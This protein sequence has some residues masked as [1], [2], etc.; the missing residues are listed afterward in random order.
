MCGGGGA[1]GAVCG[2]NGSMCGGR[3]RV[4]GMTGPPAGGGG[5]TCG[6]VVTSLSKMGG[7]N[8]GGS[9]TTRGS[10]RSTIGGSCL[11]SICGIGWMM[12]GC[13]SSAGTSTYSSTYSGT[14]ISRIFST[15]TS[16]T[17]AS[18]PGAPGTPRGPDNS[19]PAGGGT[20][21]GK[22]MIFSTMISCSSI[23]STGTWMMRPP[24]R[25]FS[26]GWGPTGW[27]TSTM[28]PGTITGTN[29]ST[30]GPGTWTYLIFS[31]TL[32]APPVAGTCFSWYTGMSLY[33]GYG[34]GLT[35][36][37]T[38]VIPTGTSRTLPGSP[39]GGTTSNLGTCLTISWICGTSTNLSTICI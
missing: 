8:R 9:F 15:G 27:G 13:P 7:R 39:V 17:L 34:M 36:S 35:F 19:K 2:G 21:G 16:T 22:G 37:T 4:G 31:T 33:T 24:G 12:M 18:S 10:P 11:Y 32:T 5:P 1:P 23:T 6:T 26:T 29:F 25:G 30:T 14:G 38:C 28:G 3:G 20:P